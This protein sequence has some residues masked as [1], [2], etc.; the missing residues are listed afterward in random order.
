MGAMAAEVRE[1]EPDQG[2]E[3]LCLQRL[4][5]NLWSEG[6]VSEARKV[7]VLSGGNQPGTKEVALRSSFVSGS[8]AF[9]P[10]VLQL[11]GGRDMP[12]VSFASIECLTFL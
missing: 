1:E 4:S 7:K 10:K 6:R 5:E 12:V 3:N 9:V 8:E 2:E 11:S